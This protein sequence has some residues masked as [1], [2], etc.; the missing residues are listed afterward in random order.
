VAELLHHE[1]AGGAPLSSVEGR[2]WTAVDHRTNL[3]AAGLTTTAVALFAVSDAVIKLLTTTYPAGQILFCRGVFALCF[4]I[5]TIRVRRP[6]PIR[7][8]LRD[9][10]TWLRSLCDFAASWSYFHA[11][12]VLPLAEAT[13]ILFAFPLTLTVL[14]ALVL[15]ERVGWVRWAAV[16]AGLLGVLVILRPGTAAFNLGAVWALGAALCIGLRDLSTRFV[17]PAVSTESVALATTGFATLAAV[18]TAPFGWV[19]PDAAGVA[20][21]AATAAL[22]SVAF[23]MIVAGTRSGDISFTAPFRYVT[24][25]LSFLLGYLIWGQVPDRYVLLGAAVVMAA[26]LLV[27]HRGAAR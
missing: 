4:L 7:L 17:R 27:V 15:K 9:R 10:A 24:V 26:G 12:K 11:L 19:L 14:A 6:G 20:G 23:V 16:A 5:F 18:A 21:F 2:R 25:P 13:A 3:R 8:P 22:V 1:K